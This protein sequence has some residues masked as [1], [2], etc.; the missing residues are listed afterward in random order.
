MRIISESPNMLVLVLPSKVHI[1]RQAKGSPQRGVF[2]EDG[3]C[4]DEFVVGLDNAAGKARLV[5]G[6]LSS[7]GHEIILSDVQ[8]KL[9][10]C[11]FRKT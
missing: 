8:V 4:N 5:S 3:P 1:F 11:Y 2:L 7:I 9:C 10:S 6:L